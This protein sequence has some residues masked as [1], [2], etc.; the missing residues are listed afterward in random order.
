MSRLPPDLLERVVDIQYLI[1]ENRLFLPRVGVRNL[2]AQLKVSSKR[3]VMPLSAA[4]DL[5]VDL[6][7]DM[8]GV[9]LSR[10]P[11]SLIEVLEPRLLK[12]PRIE[13]M[14]VNVAVKLLEKHE[15]AKRAEVRLKSDYFVEARPPH[16]DY[17]FRE[18]CK[19]YASAAAERNNKIVK[20]VGVRVS[21]FTACPC[22]Q[23]LMK[24]LAEDRLRELGYATTDIKRIFEAVPIAT[25]TQRAYNLILLEEPSGF[26]VDVED[27]IEVARGALSGGTYTILK[28]PS[29]VS[30]VKAAVERAMFVEDVVRASLASLAERYKEMPDETR[31]YVQAYSEECV[32]HQDLVAERHATLK[33][34]REELKA[35]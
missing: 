3:G 33:D 6:P 7:R 5:F 32:H 13:E 23:N 1:P 4:I 8:K 11:E 26:A 31:V 24:A 27:I 20:F 28:R 16:S 14:C 29:E 35:V 22:T 10:H 12:V 19:I 34:V 15:Y 25:H 21:G 18:P 17:T 2:K 30:V 9:N